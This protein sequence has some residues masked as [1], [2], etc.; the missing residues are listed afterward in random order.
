MSL[1]GPRPIVQDELPRYAEDADFY[2]ETRPGMT[3][4]WQIS[5]RNNTDYGYRVSLDTW[6]VKNWSMWYDVV[7]LIKTIRVVLARDGAF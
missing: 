2:L 7:I 1:V 5:G 6:Y 4:L 3:G